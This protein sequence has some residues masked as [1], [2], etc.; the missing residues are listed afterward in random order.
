MAT[1]Y[2]AT[3]GNDSNNGTSIG[4][5][6]L[7]FT[8]ADSVAVPGDRVLVQ[9]G[10]YTG[11]ITTNASGLPRLRVVYRSA[12]PLGAKITAPAT[13]P[14]LWTNNGNYVDVVGFEAD[15]TGASSTVGLL[16]YASFCSYR[17]NYVHTIT[18]PDS[19][20]F[21]AGIFHATYT[22]SDNDTIGNRVGF[23]GSVGNTNQN[24]VHG[25]YHTNL[26]GHIQNNISYQCAGHGIQLWHGAN[27][28]TIANN[29]IFKTGL[30]GTTGGMVVGAVTGEGSGIDGNTTVSN[31]ILLDIT[32]HAILEID[33]IGTGN[34]YIN[35]LIRNYTTGISVKAQ[36]TVSGTLDGTDPQLVNYQTD[37]S[38]D[39]HLRGTSPCV[40]TGTAI[41]APFADFDGR[42]CSS[43]TGFSI[44]PYTIMA[45][46][47]FSSVAL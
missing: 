25:I 1:Y 24:L 38:G 22:A 2:I 21:G 20:Q 41:G 8:K 3:T 45:G 32:G 28:V 6:F 5:P 19:L 36:S 42:D 37:G 33:P 16:N 39:Y 46:P 35:N 29:L 13:T 18:C 7:T 43:I 17:Q 31:N 10:T 27:N 4:T 15:G 14:Y 26:R 12:T 34:Q 47:V 44:G 11:P 40:R 23:I 9:P 30:G